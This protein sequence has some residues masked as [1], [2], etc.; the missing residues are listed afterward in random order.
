METIEIDKVGDSEELQ[1]AMN[2]IKDEISKFE[3]ELQETYD[4]VTLGGN[5]GD[6]SKTHDGEDY[7]DEDEDDKKDESA[8]EKFDDVTLGGNKGDKSKTHDGE[9]YEDED[10]DEDKKDEAVVEKKSKKDYLNDGYVESTVTKAG[11][12]LRKNQ[13]VMVSAEEYSSLGDD[14]MLEVIDPR[15]GKTTIIQKANLKV[16]I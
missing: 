10:E 8:N 3:K 5:K 16:Q 11:S 15:N 12:G 1:E 4:D 9:D 2:L 14:D 7:E 6:K 13:E